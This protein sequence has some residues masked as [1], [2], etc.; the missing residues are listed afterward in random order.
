MFIIT[1]FIFFLVAADASVLSDA[2][3]T[4]AINRKLCENGTHSDPVAADFFACYDEEITPGGGQFVRCQLEVFGVL[5]NTEENVDSVCAQGDKFPQY[6]DC[7]IL[8][9]IGIGVNPAVAVHLLNV[10][11]GAVLDVPEPP[12]RLIS[13]K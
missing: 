8:G 4:A 5:I 2:E 1:I 6:S 3:W 10:C 9:L 11:Q 12:P 13:T 7:I